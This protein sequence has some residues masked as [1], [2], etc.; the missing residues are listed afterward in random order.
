LNLPQAPKEGALR[1]SYR[2]AHMGGWG[3]GRARLKSYLQLDIKKSLYY[4]EENNN[5][6]GSFSISHT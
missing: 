1:L 5:C 6:A 4:N 2:L 3:K